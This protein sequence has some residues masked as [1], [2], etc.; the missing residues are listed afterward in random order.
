MSATDVLWSQSGRGNGSDSSYDD[1]E[2]NKQHT[3]IIS[4]VVIKIIVNQQGNKSI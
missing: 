2:L 4:Y 1:T 3:V